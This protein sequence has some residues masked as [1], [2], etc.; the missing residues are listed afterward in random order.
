MKLN[1]AAQ[2]IQHCY[3]ERGKQR[4]DVI[5]SFKEKTNINV[6]YA[7]GNIH[8][9][10][11]DVFTDVENTFSEHCRSYGGV[12]VMGNIEGKTEYLLFYRTPEIMQSFHTLKNSL[13]R[14]SEEVRE[15]IKEIEEQHGKPNVQHCF[16]D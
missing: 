4:A 16:L 6:G 12:S 2:Y 15:I 7:F 13:E 3:K 10:I 11:K 8:V 9:Q 1:S 5:N 14:I